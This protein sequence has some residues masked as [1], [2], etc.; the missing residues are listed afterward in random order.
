MKNPAS[1]IALI[2]PAI[3]AIL[4]AI[5]GFMYFQ[6]ANT[7]EIDPLDLWLGPAIAGG[8]GLIFLAIGGVLYFALRSPETDGTEEA[9][10]TMIRN[11][12]PHGLPEVEKKDKMLP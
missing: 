2:F 9:K 7:P 11:F 3:G 12:N 6:G 8:T 10:N 1:A 5:G 4:I